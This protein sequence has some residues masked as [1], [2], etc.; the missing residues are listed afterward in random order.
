[1]LDVAPSLPVLSRGWVS[2]ACAIM[3]ASA[4][5]LQDETV[6]AKDG[7]FL[8]ALPDGGIEALRGAGRFTVERTVPFF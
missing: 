8:D 2:P 3:F 6:S 1:M 4:P 5:R 7:E